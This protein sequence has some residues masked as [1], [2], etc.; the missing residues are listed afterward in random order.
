MGGYMVAFWRSTQDF[1]SVSDHGLLW[2]NAV[3]P[4]CFNLSHP[5]SVISRF[6]V[7]SSTGEYKIREAEELW[8]V[9][10]LMNASLLPGGFLLRF[11]RPLIGCIMVK[12]VKTVGNDHWKEE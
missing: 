1:I 5:D 10:E 3:I 11:L 9:A 2:I 6:K 12:A 8:S 4:V 7:S